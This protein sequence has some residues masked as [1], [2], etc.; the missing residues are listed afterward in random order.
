MMISEVMCY[1]SPTSHSSCNIR[2][3]SHRLKI[4]GISER[5]VVGR[6]RDTGKTRGTLHKSN[7]LNSWSHENNQE[8]SIV[9]ENKADWFGTDKDKQVVLQWVN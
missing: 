5:K 9:A 1:G 4:G 8:V 7:T 2:K 6:V 3:K